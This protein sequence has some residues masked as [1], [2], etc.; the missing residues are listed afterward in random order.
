LIFDRYMH[1]KEREQNKGKGG[2]YC[3]KIYYMIFDFRC[4]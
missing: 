3:V 2:K 1:E 4:Q